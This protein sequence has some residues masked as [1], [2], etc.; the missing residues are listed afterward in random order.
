MEAEI[1]G[2]GG[3]LCTVVVQG[4]GPLT[5]FDLKREVQRRLHVQ[6]IEHLL[7][8]GDRGLWDNAERLS[9]LGP[10]PLRL[11]LVRRSREEVEF[12]KL[13]RPPL[14]PHKKNTQLHRE[15]SETNRP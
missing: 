2:I 13:L 6:P 11:S 14:S 5:V 10:P 4:R 7:L 9:S 8:L 1:C 15:A 3:P 12:L